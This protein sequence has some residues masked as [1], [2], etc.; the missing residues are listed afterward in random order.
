MSS[1]PEVTQDVLDSI[2][3]VAKSGKTNMLDRNVVQYYANEMALYDLVAFIEVKP[4]DY[5]QG[6]I[7][8]FMVVEKKLL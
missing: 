3:A 5:A 6:I 1:K 8:G 4:N 7:H 2:K